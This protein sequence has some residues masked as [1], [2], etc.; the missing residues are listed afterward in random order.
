MDDD[1][2]RALQK[3]CR[4]TLDQVQ[5]RN[6]HAPHASREVLKRGDGPADASSRS[7]W[8]TGSA[9][10]FPGHENAETFVERLGR[11]GALVRDPL[12][13]AALRGRPLDLSPRTVR[14]RFLRATGL[15]RGRI[16]QIER[17]QSAAALLQRGRLISD[18][19]HEVGYYDQP[20]LTRS[21]KQWVGHTP[22]QILRTGT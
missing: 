13:D 21:L 8:L 15:T 19:V 22:A 2:G 18:A 9:W 20:H 6:V 12:V 16:R 17:A 5:T 1:G 11:G 10:E 3:R 7:F 4:D 14:H